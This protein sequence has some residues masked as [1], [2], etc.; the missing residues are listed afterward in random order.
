MKTLYMRIK[1]RV[2]SRT[3]IWTGPLDVSFGYRFGPLPCRSP[4]FHIETHDVKCLQPVGTS[5]YA[6]DYAYI[7][8]TKLKRLT[9]RT[10]ARRLPMSIRAPRANPFFPC[11]ARRARRSTASRRS[12]LPPKPTSTLLAGSAPIATTTWARSSPGADVVA[13]VAR[14]IDG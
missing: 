9:G 12:W 14:G 7:R 10:R 3:L 11:L 4:E 5:N 13:T 6:I 2:S 1:N 8:T